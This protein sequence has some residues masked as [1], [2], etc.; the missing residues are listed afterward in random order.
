MKKAINYFKTY[1]IHDLKDMLYKTTMKNSTKTAFK[2]KDIDG[3]IYKKTFIDFQKDVEAL[4]TKLIQ[5]GLKNKR[6]AIM[7]KNS[8]TW[9][10]SYLAAVIVGI[11]VPIDKELSSSNVINFLKISKADI[12]ISDIKYIEKI[13]KE[14]ELLRKNLILVDMQNTLKYTNWSYLVDDRKSYDIKWR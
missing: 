11:V 12:F 4:G 14:K 8:Y 9:A 5:M 13:M 2:L 1:E 10:V 7:G 6:I 3:K